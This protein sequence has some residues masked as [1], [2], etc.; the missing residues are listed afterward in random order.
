MA[1]INGTNGDDNPLN[2]TQLDDIIYGLDGDDWIYG[3]GGNDILDGGA[4]SNRL[5]GGAGD[6]TYIIN[7]FNAGD[8]VLEGVDRGNDTVLFYGNRYDIL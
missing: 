2:G 3:S 7:G 1:I 4:G 6:D 8:A 5:Y